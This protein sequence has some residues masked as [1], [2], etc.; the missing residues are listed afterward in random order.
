MRYGIGP[1]PKLEAQVV[2]PTPCLH[3]AVMD[4]LPPQP[5]LVLDDPAA[6]DTAD[7]VFDANAH[8]GQPSVLGFG[9]R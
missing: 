7:D 6:F 5:Q 4:V 9:V 8:L 2:S 1:G 3:H